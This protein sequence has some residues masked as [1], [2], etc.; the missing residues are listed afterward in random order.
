MDWDDVE[1]G[2]LLKDRDVLPSGARYDIFVRRVRGEELFPSGFKY[3]LYYGFPDNDAPV[4]LYDNGHRGGDHHRH[5]DGELDDDYEFPG[6]ESL[7]Q[8]F[9]DEVRHY[10]QHSP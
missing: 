2:V 9:L 8:R 3:R 4:L 7:Y 6:M 5:V 10:E 1:E